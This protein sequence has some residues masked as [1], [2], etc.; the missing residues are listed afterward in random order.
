MYVFR[1]GSDYYRCPDS[2]IKSRKMVEWG[3]ELEMI[4]IY[5]TLDQTHVIKAFFNHEGSE[6]N[7]DHV[8]WISSD[9]NWEL[10]YNYLCN[11][12]LFESNGVLYN[13][14]EQVRDHI[15]NSDLTKLVVK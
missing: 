11:F 15:G 13:N 6:G 7:I 8:Y 9:V 10:K 3:T 4:P 14:L 5:P 1:S 2:F 12:I